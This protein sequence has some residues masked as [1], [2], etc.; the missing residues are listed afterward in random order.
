MG[1]LLLLGTTVPSPLEE[2]DVAVLLLTVLTSVADEVTDET[3]GE[4]EFATRD[5]AGVH[6]LAPT[7]LISDLVKSMQRR[8]CE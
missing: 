1:E 5:T 6:E 4:N 7:I 3:L 8:E 2:V